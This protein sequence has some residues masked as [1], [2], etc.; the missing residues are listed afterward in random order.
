M[1]DDVRVRAGRSLHL[2]LDI[3]HDLEC[4]TD[5][6]VARLESISG[7]LPCTTKRKRPS[8][9]GTWVLLLDE[10][11]RCVLTKSSDAF[12]RKQ[13]MCSHESK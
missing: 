9:T 3:L 2:R 13:A 8:G 7:G 1:R 10:S 11:K 5:A 12:S 6:L 4:V